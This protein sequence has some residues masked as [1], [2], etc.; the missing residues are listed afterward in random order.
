[1]VDS[2]G[3]DQGLMM[4]NVQ[5]ETDIAAGSLTFPLT[6]TLYYWES[7][8][9]MKILGLSPFH[10]DGIVLGTMLVYLQRTICLPVFRLYLTSL[11]SDAPL[12]S[13]G[14]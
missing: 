2:K 12:S 8:Y 10:V 6:C 1:M 5:V 4:M 9:C 7:C 11:L 13:D 14:R 3:V